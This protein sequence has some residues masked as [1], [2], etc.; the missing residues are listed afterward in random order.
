[1]P[2]VKSSQSSASW[3]HHFLPTNLNYHLSLKRTCHVSNKVSI[4]DILLNG[5]QQDT[6]WTQLYSQVEENIFRRSDRVTK[7]FTPPFAAVC[8]ERHALGLIYPL[9]HQITFHCNGGFCNFHVIFDICWL[10]L[11]L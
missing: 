10:D 1:M 5:L 11:Y 6:D 7:F 9:S 8:C 4:S 2:M 3:P